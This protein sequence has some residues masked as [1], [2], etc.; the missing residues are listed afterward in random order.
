MLTLRKKKGSRISKL[1]ALGNFSASPNWSTRPT[2]GCG[3]RSTSLWV[4][5]NLYWQ[6]SRDGN[7]HGFGVSHATTA[8]SKPSSKAP[9]LKGARRRVQQRKCWMDNVKEWTSLPMP[10]PLARASGRNDWK[11][12]SADSSLLFPRRPIRSRD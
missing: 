9:T 6:L 1:S 2:T 8:S 5:R 12:I 11:T 7:S 4:H 3:A 10:K